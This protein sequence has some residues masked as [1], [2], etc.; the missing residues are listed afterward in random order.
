MSFLF[1]NILC[2]E[3]EILLLYKNLWTTWNMGGPPLILALYIPGQCLAY[4]LSLNECQVTNSE[5]ELQSIH[6][7]KVQYIEL[8]LIL[9]QFSFD[10][11]KSI[12]L[13]SLPSKFKMESPCQQVK[14]FCNYGRIIYYKS[15]MQQQSTFT[16]L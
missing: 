8:L 4:I 12:W 3:R 5:K 14:V 6:D 2:V 15:I 10:R 9:M 11:K 7:P 13:G 16:F 1:V